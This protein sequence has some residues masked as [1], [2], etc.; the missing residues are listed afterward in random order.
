MTLPCVPVGDPPGN[1]TIVFPGGMRI[2]TPPMFRPYERLVELES[3]F[4]ALAPAIAAMAPVFTMLEALVAVMDFSKALATL[5]PSE[6]ADAF[7]AFLEAMEKLLGIVPQLSLPLMILGL[8]QLILD[9]LT[10]MI[11]FLVDIQRQQQQVQ[12]MKDYAQEHELEPMVADALCLE[13]NLEARMAYFNNAVGALAVFL[14][15]VETLGSIAGLDISLDMELDEDTDID[16][17][18]DALSTFVDTLTEIMAVVE[19]V[20]P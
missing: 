18:L 4:Q 9:M 14:V 11:D 2:S 17:M 1:H 7:G 6:I 3:M 10:T 20:I 12:T 5:N 15:L 19:A 13:Q 8:L 16:D